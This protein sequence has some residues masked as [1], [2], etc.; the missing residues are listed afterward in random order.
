MG[1]I[2]TPHKLIAS[3]KWASTDQLLKNTAHCGKNH[4]LS[5]FAAH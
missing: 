3:L 5:F 4:H 1:G 2:K